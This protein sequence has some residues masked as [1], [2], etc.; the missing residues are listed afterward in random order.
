[1][2]LFLDNAESILDPRGTDAQEIY[3][4]VEELCQ[5]SNI[6]LCITSRI[7][8]IPPT[9]E[10]LEIPTL[11]VEAARDTFY[12]IYK[13]SGQ[14]DLVNSIL[15]QLDF[16]P[17]SITLLATVARHNK[18]DVDRLGREWERQRTDVLHTRHDQ[19]FAATIK[20]SLASPMFQE[21]G[22]DARELLA[23][24]AFFPQGV[25][26]NNLGWLFPTL[27]NRTSIFD[28]FCILSLA[29]RSN[30]F[31]A[32]LAPLRD[33]LRPKDPASSPLLCTTRDHY[34]SRLSA[35]VNPGSPAFEEAQWITSEDV[36]VEHLLDIFTSADANLASV[37]DACASFMEHLYW[38]KPRLVALEPKI[39]GL[40]DDH[41]SKPQC[42]FELSRLFDSVGNHTECK[43]LL[44]HTLKLWRE[45]GDD[46][47]VA[48]TLRF[49]AGANR[50]LSL[51]KEGI[52]QVKEALGI[53]E[54]RNEILGQ[55]Q[56]LQ[57]LAWLLYSD[58]QLDAAEEAA[59]RAINLPLNK[60]Q[61]FPACECYR[62]LGDIY[63]SRG[64][65]E[66]AIDHYEMALGIASLSNWHSQLCV[67]HYCLAALFID[68][69][70]FDGAHAHIEH[71]K[72]YAINDA[73]SLG[74]ATKLQARLLYQ[75]HRFEEAKAETS[76]A[77]DIFEKLGAKKYVENCSAL[78]QMI[79]NAT[80]EPAASRKS[81]SNGEPPTA[82]L[83][84]AR[85]DSGS[86]L[87]TALNYDIGTILRICSA[88]T[89]T[90]HLPHIG[91][92]IHFVSW[93]SYS[94][95]L[96]PLPPFSKDTITLVD[97]L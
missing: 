69:K 32:M 71:A 13:N 7:S 70:R 73:Y 90:N 94:P 12:R 66:K 95:Q 64:E 34:F 36:N 54:Q 63:R 50:Q 30:G 39:K 97:F 77:A 96:P 75:Q 86:T 56:S 27:S 35:Y 17:L 65:T 87:S 31:I 2:I 57:Y 24:V 76:R 40:P 59:S 8:T 93:L 20:L 29:Y 3:A 81:D 19:S 72:S 60:D 38:H 26:E 55:A 25:N 10:I 5:F 11:S 62:L 22:P 37:W 61:Q 15:G 47:K 23:V 53:Y 49:M 78:L 48:N 58:K 85:I 18:W 83:L 67:T 79:E 51:H 6:C 41:R 52:L 46:V 89:S 44:G 91:T 88:Y 4:M 42:L 1:M 80:D 82:V 28:S 21:L 92:E 14:P 74:H 33:H 16:H 45:W 9:C 43:L 84:P 68:G